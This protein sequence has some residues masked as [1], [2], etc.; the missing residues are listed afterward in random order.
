L[1]EKGEKLNACG[2]LL[3]KGKGGKEIIHRKKHLHGFPI[4]YPADWRKKKK[5]G[6]DPTLEKGRKRRKGEREGADPSYE[7]V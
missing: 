5:E 6:F 1:L 4:P 3:R 7:P 2:P